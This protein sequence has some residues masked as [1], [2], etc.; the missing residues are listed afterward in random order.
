VCLHLQNLLVGHALTWGWKGDLVFI[1]APNLCL[2]VLNRLPLCR[3]PYTLTWSD[4]GYK[5]L[6]K[7]IVMNFQCLVEVK[8]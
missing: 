7:G 4:S 8:L 2:F 3:A 5:Y 6:C 1:L